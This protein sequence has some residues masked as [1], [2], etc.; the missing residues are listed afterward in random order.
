[1]YLTIL[2]AELLKS[3]H[4]LADFNRAPARDYKRASRY[5]NMTDP[6]CNKES[7]IYRKEDII[8]LKPGRENA[9]L[10]A[11]VEKVLQRISC[12]LIRVR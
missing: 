6:L 5:F 8:S 10:D 3:A 11:I 2:V 1:M 7:Y 12:P 9:W 4:D